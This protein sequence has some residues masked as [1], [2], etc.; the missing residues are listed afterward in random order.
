MTSKPASP[1]RS[2]SAPRKLHL[3]RCAVRVTYSPNRVSGKWAGIN[4]L[5]GV[6]FLAALMQPREL[7]PMIQCRFCAAIED[8]TV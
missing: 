7:H 6:S 4:A 8:G 5:L 3:E 2:G 1:A